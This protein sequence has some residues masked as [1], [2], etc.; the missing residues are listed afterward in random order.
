MYGGEMEHASV[1]LFVSSW[2]LGADLKTDS[3]MG[4]VSKL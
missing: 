1:P 2:H 3:S 4:E